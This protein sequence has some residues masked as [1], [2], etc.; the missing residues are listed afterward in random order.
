MEKYHYL[1]MYTVITGQEWWQKIELWVCA[2]WEREAPQNTGAGILLK[3]GGNILDISAWEE[4]VT[5]RWIDQA[6]N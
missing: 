2:Q 4:T 3:I 5:T 1:K 6:E